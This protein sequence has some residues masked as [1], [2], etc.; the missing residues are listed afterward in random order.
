MDIQLISLY[1][2]SITLASDIKKVFSTCFVSL[3]ALATSLSQAQTIS[4]DESIDGDLGSTVFYLGTL[5]EG[6]NTIKASSSAM[7]SQIDRDF[8]WLS[9][10]EGLQ[11]TDV[12]LD[13]TSISDSSNNLIFDFDVGVYS[14]S[15]LADHR[16]HLS[17]NNVSE[18]SNTSAT[19][20]SDGDVLL[21]NSF[22]LAY[23]LVGPQNL[24]FA[25]HTA[26]G[27]SWNLSFDYTWKITVEQTFTNTEPSITIQSPQNGD[28]FI[29]NSDTV[30]LSATA[31]DFDDGDISANVTWHSDIDGDIF[32]PAALSLG[33]HTITANIEDSHGAVASDTVTIE[34]EVAT[35]D[36]IK[37]P[38][39]GSNSGFV[40]VL[41]IGLLALRTKKNPASAGLF[42]V[43][44][45]KL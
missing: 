15:T 12:K 17:H 11:I 14:G 22:K 18:D 36:N 39:S 16:F 31:N 37:P 32:S 30:A 26:Q 8:P 29:V 13:L 44:N 2:T 33:T 7:N 20:F 42:N 6:I 27:T 35:E 45:I 24:E 25:F 4:Y 43:S 34:V 21:D 38:K 41:L 3:L 28:R 1:T 9:L 10:P 5:D 19:A 40:Y 23:P